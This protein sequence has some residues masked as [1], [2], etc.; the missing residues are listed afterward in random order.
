MSFPSMKPNDTYYLT[1]DASDNGWGVCLSQ[2]QN[3][4]GY[5]V[6]LSFGSGS[7]ANAEV[8]WPI[9]EKEII[10]FVKARSFILPWCSTYRN[11]EYDKEDFIEILY[12]KCN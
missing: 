10:S 2:F 6:P 4:K 7:F 5:E 8:N 1:T 3:D 11:R 9:K 12:S